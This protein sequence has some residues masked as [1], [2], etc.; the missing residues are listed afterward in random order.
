VVPYYP[1]QSSASTDLFAANGYQF[2]GATNTSSKQITVKT[3]KYQLLDF[4]SAK[5]VRQPELN[6]QKLAE[7]AGESEVCSTP[8][9]VC[10]W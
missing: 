1:L 8:Q 7:M 5:I 6:L 9:Q 3:R 2:A 4:S 10:C